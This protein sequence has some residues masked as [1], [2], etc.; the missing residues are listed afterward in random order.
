ML[1]RVKGNQQRLEQVFF[2]LL[3]NALT[4]TPANGQITVMAMAAVDSISVR[5][6]DNGPGI[7]AEH[8]PRLFERFYRVDA[9]RSREQGGTGLGLAIVKHIV[10]LHGG[11][12]GV[13]STPGAGATFSFSLPIEHV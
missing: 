10:L 13:E 8:L 9:S 12:V 5:I 7:S 11:S 3:D 6:S 1:P 4:Y 2:N